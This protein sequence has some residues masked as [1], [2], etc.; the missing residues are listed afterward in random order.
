MKVG[1]YESPRVDNTRAT[2]E[3]ATLRLN[4]CSDVFFVL[5]PRSY[6]FVRVR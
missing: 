4:S 3:R 5:H 6:Y 2:I 1:F